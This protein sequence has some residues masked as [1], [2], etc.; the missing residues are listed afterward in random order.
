MTREDVRIIPLFM[1][2]VKR[3]HFGFLE[4]FQA[5]PYFV[6]EKNLK[7]AVIDILK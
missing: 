7:D 6:N 3:E 4:G 1:E 5:L 2:G